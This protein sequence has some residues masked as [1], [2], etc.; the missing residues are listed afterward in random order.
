MFIGI[1]IRIVIR[2]LRGGQGPE[3]GTERRPRGPP[4]RA[5]GEARSLGGWR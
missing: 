4:R 3:F 5:T 2:L 1:I